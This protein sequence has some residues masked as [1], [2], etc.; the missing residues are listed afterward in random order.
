MVRKRSCKLIH[1]KKRVRI[2][3]K[4]YLKFRVVIHKNCNY[5]YEGYKATGSSYHIFSL[6]PELS[7][8]VKPPVIHHVVIAFRQKFHVST[9]P[10]GTQER[11]LV[12]AG[13]NKVTCPAY[14]TGSN[15]GGNPKDRMGRFHKELGRVL[16][17][18]WD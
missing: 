14:N 7:R 8:R 13:V 9:F 17:V 16:H 11:A 12:S 5:A 15:L 6:K 18:T 3:A 1:K 2:Q 4:A 10:R